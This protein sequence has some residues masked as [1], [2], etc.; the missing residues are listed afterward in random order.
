HGGSARFGGGGPLEL[1]GARSLLESSRALPAAARHDRGRS[2]GLVRGAFAASGR[3]PV[4]DLEGGLLV[5]AARCRVPAGAL[6]V[7]GGGLRRADGHRPAGLPGADCSAGASA[8]AVSGRGVGRDRSRERFTSAVEFGTGVR[9][10]RDLYVGL[11]G[12]AEGSGGA[13][14]GD[15]EPGAVD[16]GG[17]SADRRRPCSAEN[18][19]ELRRVDLGAVSAALGGRGAGPGGAGRSPGQRVFGPSR[20]GISDHGVAAGAVD[21]AGVSRRAERLELHELAVSVCGR[22]SALGRCRSA[23]GE[24]SAGGGAGEPLWS[25][26]SGDRRGVEA[27]RGIRDAGGG[28]SRSADLLRA[29][30]GDG[31]D[32][33]GGA[34]RRRGGAV[35][36][37]G[38]PGLR[39]PGAR[40]LD[41]GA[42]RCG[43]LVERGRAGVS[44]GRSGA[45]AAGRRA[46]VPGPDRYAGEGTGSADRAGRD[47]GGSVGASGGGADGGGGSGSGQRLAPGGVLGGPAGSARDGGG[48]ARA[49]G[50][51]PA[52][53]DGAGRADGARGAAGSAERQG[54]S[55]RSAGAGGDR[56]RRR[57]AAHS[58]G[59]GAGGDLVR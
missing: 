48:A 50:A 58:G 2:G 19:L 59:R 6:G 30:G 32:R 21:A 53:G 56:R 43:S 45:L 17:V 54:G 20:H 37:R 3:E 14:P 36:R 44:N 27:S 46:R 8:V 31:S 18:S 24:P 7:F 4:G 35:D 49:R 13:A 33:A 10:V 40:G 22:R 42:V 26:G 55:Q 51:A 41:G 23:A 34:D 25:D 47:R 12:G 5:R 9:G 39:L 57:S 16:A 28:A 52:G 1:R 11:D 38:E 15:R 29:P